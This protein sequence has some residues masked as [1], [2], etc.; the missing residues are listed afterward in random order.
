[1]S[2]FDRCTSAASFPVRRT[3][4]KILRLKVRTEI[5]GY[6]S[7]SASFRES[8]TPVSE[9]SLMISVRREVIPISFV[10]PN[11]GLLQ[12]YLE[13]VTL[14]NNFANEAF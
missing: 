5:K 14:K 11:I 6:K 2:W 9:S 13:E 3:N 1:M 7:I 4:C 10:K 12:I 8:Q